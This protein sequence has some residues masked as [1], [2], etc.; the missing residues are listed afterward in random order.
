MIAS[1]PE[2]AAAAPRML[3]ELAE[4]LRPPERL[5][6]SEWAAEHRHLMPGTTEKS[7]KWD[8]DFFP[9]LNPIMDAFEEAL[10]EGY[11]GFVLMKGAQGGGSEAMLNTLFWARSLFTGPMCY[12]ISKDE[13]AKEFGRERVDYANQKSEPLAKI[14]LGEKKGAGETIQ[15]KRY[16]TG[17]LTILGGRSVLNMESTPYLIVWVDE[18]DS[19]QDN[20]PGKGDLIKTIKARTKAFRARTLIAAFAHPTTRE[21]GAGKLYYG[22]SD[23]RRGFVDCPHCAEAAAFWLDWDHVQVFPEDGETLEQAQRNPRRY[24]FVAPC[25]GAV[26]SDG[27]RW[28]ALRTVRQISTL[29]EEE[30]DQKRWLG[31]HFSEL[32]YPHRTLEDLA[33][34]WIDGIDS[35]SVRRVTVNK[36][37]GD[38]YEPKVRE[39]STEDWR[40]LIWIPRYEGDPE[41]YTRGEVPPGVRFLTAGQDSRTVELHWA[42]WGWGLVRNLGGFPELVGW[43]VDCGI[44]EREHTETIEAS[45]LAIFDQL[46]LRR[47]FPRS[48]GSGYLQVER[49]Y[50]DSGWCPLAVAEFVR[51][52][53]RAYASKGGSDD[54]TTRTP[55]HRWGA[56]MRYMAPNGETVT[57]PQTKPALL[58]TYKLKE[59]WFGLVAKTFERPDPRGGEL[60]DRHPRLVLPVDVPEDFLEQSSTEYLAKNKRGK[61]QWQSSSHAN[62]FSDCNVEAYAAA[63]QLN[64]FQRGQTRDE[65]IRQAEEA[66]RRTQARRV[67]RHE[68]RRSRT[69]RRRY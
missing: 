45:D 47:S 40:R 49:A 50:F 27:D 16:S 24:H 44:V 18:V 3:A 53:E 14:W 65:T 43:L 36:S 66:A 1:L 20:L 17:K 60:P 12:L 31:V 32:Y 52:R 37:H 22:S 9:H 46:L 28:R 26:L 19:L 11:E 54:E 56:P 4:V 2:A 6:P 51:T 41:A 55:V 67:D 33:A 35:E 69:I 57:D 29:S 21:Q 5:S 7:G 39:T 63:L 8:P 48:D 38:V 15:I 68:R 42:V 13:L 10:E 34:D 23:Q 64:P 58:N 62:H 30:R 59:Q 25:C 61:L